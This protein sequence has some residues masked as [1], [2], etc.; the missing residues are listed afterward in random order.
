MVNTILNQCHARSMSKGVI[1]RIHIPYMLAK[2][3]Y[4]EWTNSAN[5]MQRSKVTEVESS[6]IETEA[7]ELKHKDFVVALYL[8]GMHGNKAEEQACLRK[9]LSAIENSTF[10]GMCLYTGWD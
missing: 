8:M 2:Q 1:L 9:H 4:R 6:M 10:S 3:K 7:M 5:G